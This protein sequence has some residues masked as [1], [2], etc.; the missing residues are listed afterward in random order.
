MDGSTLLDGLDEAQRAA[1]TATASP[2]CI[3]AGAGSGK[4]RALTRRIAWRCETGDADPR[5]VLALTFTRKAAGELKT[6]LRALGLRDDVTAG[7]F[8]AIAYATLRARWAERGQ[9]PPEL[10]QSKIRLLMPHSRGKAFTASD[11]AGEIE[12]AKARMIAAH[13]YAEAAVAAGRRPPVPPDDMARIYQRYEEA[14]RK[15]RQVDFD[16]LLALCTGEMEQHA[17]FAAAQRWRYRHLFVDEFQDVNPLQF[18][19]LEAWRGPSLDLCVVGDPNQ[20][21]YAWNGADA[22]YLTRFCDRFPGAEVVT[23]DRNYR[24]SPQVVAVANAVLASS[25]VR[26]RLHATCQDGQLPVIRSYATDVLEAAAIARTVRDLNGP[27]VPWSHQAV[28]VRTN[29]QAQLLERAF[30]KAQVPCR[31]KG[32]AA[33]LELPEVKDALRVIARAPTLADA[34]VEIDVREE[35]TDEM[36]EAA[37]ERVRNVGE[38]VRLLNEYR[39]MDAGGRPAEFVEWLTA[40][41]GREDNDRGDRV[42]IA[43]FHAA[44]GLEWPIVHLAGLEAGLVPIGLA[45]SPEA[46]EEERR[47]FYVAV[48]RAERV[49]RCSWAEQRTF[50]TRTSNRSPSPFLD[51]VEHVLAAL[52]AGESVEDWRPRIAAPRDKLRAASPRA[53][54]DDLA[55]EHRPLFDALKQW[56]AGAARAANVPAF[57][58]FHDSTLRALAEARPRTP[59]ALLAVPGIGPVKATRFGPDVLAVVAATA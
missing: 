1:V 53:R 25:G 59:T 44:K 56:R 22:G 27:Q 47:L 51:E 32:R 41:L 24:S 10:L 30:S 17:E 9:S 58:I 40:T 48:T 29:A 12:W 8:H 21:I 23:L 19:L 6:R 57:V 38:L 3:L 49:L 2:L 35:P 7:T 20:A 52:A 36:S 54:R 46:Q 5:H 42:D 39:A 13:E 34:L 28:L 4:T 50:G 14:K 26:F 18:R 37:L 31:V 33:F 15:A 11:L 43:T 45:K 55:V 16:D